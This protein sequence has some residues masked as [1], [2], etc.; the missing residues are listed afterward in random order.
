[1][2]LDFS[3]L[4]S[5]TSYEPVNSDSSYSEINQL[6]YALKE[7]SNNAFNKA[8]IRSQVDNINQ[9]SNELMS[10]SQVQVIND[11][12]ANYY[13]VGGLNVNTTV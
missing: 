2:S 5:T 11:I 13:G 8:G 9:L 3:S 12:A 4:Q 1:M 7:M 6:S 10:E